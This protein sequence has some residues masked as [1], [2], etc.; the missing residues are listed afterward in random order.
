MVHRGPDGEGTHTEPQVN[1]AM[2]R[3]SIIDLEGGMQPLY[4]EDG[5]VVVVCNGEI[6]NAVEL[7]KEL[8][9]DGHRFATGSD[10]ETIV[11]AYEQLGLAF[12]DKLRGMFALAVWDKR[13][14][15]LIL[16]RDRMGEKPLYIYETND[17][18]CFASELKAILASGLIPFRL[19]PRA[20]DYYFTHLY[21]PDPL[22]P[23]EGVTRLPAGT[24]LVCD[25]GAWQLSRICYWDMESVP[26]V[27]VDRIV[28]L[29]ESLRDMAGVVVR[30]DVPVGVALS[31]GVDS[32]LVAALARETYGESLQAF[33]IGYKGLPECDEREDAGRFARELGIPFHGIE[34]DTD[35]MVDEFDALNFWRDEPIADIAGHGYWYVMKAA[36]E[37]GVRV[38]LQGQGGDELFWG[39]SWV[40]RAVTETL[41][42]VNRKRYGR[43]ASLGYAAWLHPRLPEGVAPWQIRQWFGSL[44]GMQADVDHIRYHAKRPGDQFAFLDAD[45]SARRYLNER[46]SVFTPAALACL[47][48]DPYAELYT[49]NKA[50]AVDVP[51][52][53]MKW[54]CET[55]LRVNGIVQGDRLGMAASVELRLPLI[56]YR[57]VESVIGMNRSRRLDREPPKSV[58]KS[59]AREWLPDWLMSRPKR[60]FTPP[61]YEW[62]VRLA[63]RYG[64]QLRDGILV[65]E[66]LVRRGFIEERFQNSPPAVSDAEWI[67]KLLV[68]ESWA[69]QM[70][71]VCG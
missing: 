14:R 12:I 62:Y 25:I 8:E 23:V 48:A 31:G 50:D 33:T 44:F 65:K 40:R 60:G 57:V 34:V 5:Q 71:R 29:G 22:T 24:L 46:Q 18:L 42:R 38:M 55:Y 58:L 56:D 49:V 45:R 32:S 2:R 54:I 3:L 16:G 69:R 70:A 68:F 67:Y 41:Q 66:S 37:Q 9:G 13:E 53:V 6:Y 64:A 61:V 51:L 20:L 47:P 63:D 7:R 26:V 36:H 19:N 52:R 10:C 39:Y 43:L 17:S 59:V 28:P 11:H 35:E 4:S 27:G 21:V 1:I 15:K 30:S